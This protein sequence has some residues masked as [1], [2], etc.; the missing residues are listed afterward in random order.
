MV[1]F[2]FFFSSFT[3]LWLSAASWTAALV[4]LALGV[5]FYVRHAAFTRNNAESKN[6]NTTTGVVIAHEATIF[7]LYLHYWTL[8][9]HNGRILD[10]Q[11]H[12][13]PA[14]AWMEYARSVLFGPP[15]CTITCIVL[16]LRGSLG[17]GKPIIPRRG[18]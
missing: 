6:S 10:I 1:D 17:R 5:L 9:T 11:R 15:V 3:A 13:T 4:V 8:D 16:L 7:L 12:T 14:H 2:F 18:S